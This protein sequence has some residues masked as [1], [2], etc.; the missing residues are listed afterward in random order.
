MRGDDAM[1]KS[2]IDDDERQKAHERRDAEREKALDER[3]LIAQ[4]AL[5]TSCALNAARVEYQAAKRRLDKAEAEDREA[6][7]AFEACFGARRGTT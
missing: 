1:S 5:E 4:R 2:N 7:N 3:L 6:R